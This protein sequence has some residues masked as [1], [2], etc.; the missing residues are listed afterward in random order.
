MHLNLTLEEKHK[1]LK[2]I[3]LRDVLKWKIHTIN[4]IWLQRFIKYIGLSE[5]FTH[6][7]KFDS[8]SANL[9]F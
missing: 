4:F 5:Y 2:Q 6:S 9:A 3:F 8:K 1:V 7:Q